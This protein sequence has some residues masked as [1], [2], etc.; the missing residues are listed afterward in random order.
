VFDDLAAWLGVQPQ[1]IS[2]KSDTAKGV[3]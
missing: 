3:H 1:K 2:A